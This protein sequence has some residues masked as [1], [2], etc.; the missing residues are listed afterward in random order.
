MSKAR[1]TL[2]PSTQ[3]EK[4][5]E[6][7]G[8][9][10]RA[11]YSLGQ[12]YEILKMPFY[13]LYYYRSA[14][15]LRP[16]DARMWS[17]LAECYES[18]PDRQLEAIRCYKRADSVGDREGIALNKIANLYKNLDDNANAALYYMKNL[19][20]CDKEQTHGQ[21]TVDA[22]LFL[23]YYLHENAEYKRAKEYALRLYDYSTGSSK[24]KAKDLLRQ[25]E[26]S[27]TEI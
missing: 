27:N 9:D 25:I 1:I 15:S 10:Y 24:E 11:W 8:R 3:I 2:R 7:N 23:C 20:R 16:Y 19:Q 18:L 13:A 12:T 6:I 21:D 4:L 26:A 14:A 22:L 5:L 17:A